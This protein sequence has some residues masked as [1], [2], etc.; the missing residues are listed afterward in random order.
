MDLA[1][2]GARAVV[3]TAEPSARLVKEYHGRE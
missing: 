3:L 1:S 2:F